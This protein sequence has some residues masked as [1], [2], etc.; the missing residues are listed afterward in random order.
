[1]DQTL[2]GLVPDSTLT[3][4]KTFAA[5]RSAYVRSQIPLTIT[6]TNSSLSFANGLYHTTSPTVSLQGTANVIDTREVQANGTE[7][8]WTAWTGTWTVS[9]IS[10]R[11]GV[12]RVVVQSLNEAGSV[13]ER[14]GV[15]VWYDDGSVQT[16]SGTLTTDT[17]WA[18]ADGPFN[19]TDNLTVGAG[20]TL[21]VEPGTTVYLASGANLT[22]ASGG[23]LLAQGTEV[24]PIRFTR[25]P[26]TT[27]SWGGITINGGAGT[28]ETRIAYAHIDAN[29]STAIH[30][31]GGTLLLDHLT[32]GSPD[33]PYVSLD[34]SSFL[35]QDCVFPTPTAALEPMHGTGGIKA[36]GRGLVLRN[37]FGTTIG[38]SDVFDFTGGNR[39]GQAIL[40]VIGNVFS[41]SSDDE[42]DLDGTDAWIEGNL[43]LHAHKNGSPDTS[44]GISGGSDGS[45]TSEITIV[46]NI[47]YDC[48]QA[49]T[50]KQGNFYVLVNNTMVHQTHQGGLDTDG[51]VICLEDNGAAE[52][53]G[54]YLEGNIL[55]DAEKLVRNLTSATVTFTNNLLPLPW[56][57]LGGNN[58]AADPLFVHVPK[59]DET[60][61]DAWEGA[62]VMRDWLSLLPGS[63]GRGTGP[64]GRDMGAVVPLGA[65]IGGVPAG[66][67]REPGATLTVGF[68]RTGSGISASSWTEGAGYTHYRWRLDGGGWSEETPIAAPIVLSDLASGPHYVEVSGRR[69]CGW[70]QDDPAYGT[71]AG[72]TRSAT[73][74]VDPG[75]I[76]PPPR[77][78]INE[79]LAKN[80]SI[81]HEGTF[82]DLVEFYNDGSVSVDLSGCGFSTDAATPYAFLFPAGTVIP[83]KGLVVAFGDSETNAGGLHLGFALKQSGGALY[84]FDPASRGGQLLDSVRFG[85]QV[86][87]LSIGRLADGSWG[88]TQPTP[89]AANVAQR[90]GDPAQLR[91]NEWLAATGSVFGDD[92]IELYNLD[93]FPVALGGLLVSDHPICPAGLAGVQPQGTPGTVLPPLSFIAGK[94]LVALIA[95]GAV[96]RGGDHLGFRLP[97]E[98]GAISLSTTAPDQAGLPPGVARTGEVLDCVVYGPQ[99]PDVSEGRSPNGAV[100]FGFFDQP[101]PGGGNPG[102]SD[103]AVTTSLFPLVTLTNSWK[104]WQNGDRG[105]TWR[106]ETYDD[107]A[108]PSGRAPLGHDT[109]TMP[110]PYNT[111]LTIGK[112]TYYFRTHFN[113]PTNPAGMTLQLQT[114][115]DDGAAVWLNGQVLYRQSLSAP[116]PTYDTHADSTVDNAALEGPFDID[117]G[118]LR[119]G[120]NV[121][122]VEVHQVNASS[123]DITFALRVDAA[124]T[125]T[126]VSGDDPAVRLN[127][128]LASNASYTNTAGLAPDW[129]ELYNAASTPADLTDHSLTPDSADP[130]RYVFPV[131]SVVPARGFLVIECEGRLPASP[132]NSGFDLAGQGGAIFLFDRTSRG[133]GLLDSI[134]YGVQATD[135][136]IGRVPDGSGRWQ[137]NLPTRGAAD[138]Q[139]ATG[140]AA[141]V[142]INEWMARP[143]SGDDW[144]ELYNPNNQPVELGGLFLSDDLNDRTLSEISPLSYLG[145]RGFAV[146]HADGNPYQGGNHVNFKL[147]AEGES[148]GLFT[149][150]GALIDGVTFGP[151]TDAVSEGRLPDGGA[152]F[153]T[154]PGRATPGASNGTLPVA[155]TD[156]DG[157]PD[158]WEQLYGLNA[159][160]PTDAGADLDGDGLSNLDEYRAGTRPNDPTSSLGLGFVL[161]PDRVT[162]QF[163]AVAG[164]TYSLLYRDALGVG[165]WQKL[166]D[167][168]P[169]PSDGPVSQDDF[170]LA[171]PPAQ[172]YYRLVTPELP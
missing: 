34:D 88:L 21:T 155:D 75:F 12:N 113:C 53:A 45:R 92:F 172:R 125:V 28:P 96:D 20:A 10:L 144:F 121:L 170:L 11:P 161:G 25:L 83:A 64:N 133:G 59:V 117:R 108:W 9:G 149:A 98:E 122:A 13:F 58:S 26:G 30:S 24:A 71:D 132:T 44:S 54:M 127:E 1:M 120:D 95:D 126:N 118:T 38:Y 81:G 3:N 145:P 61:F 140:N 137:A 80:R 55:Y 16:A 165:S 163:N 131:G 102:G 104:Y 69:D 48:D 101:S 67:T 27:T 167:Y 162:L 19:I 76:P 152:S 148:I 84:L 37:F 93:P 107:T 146:F 40:Q 39:P 63:P 77:V 150:Q 142:R 82:P 51:A 42:L 168:G 29:G 115:L 62:Q 135:F 141:F 136:S 111:P 22:V 52:A 105:L 4:L 147:A 49:V 56:S 164:R 68:N 139:A 106:E 70:Y 5:E 6:I 171:A 119:E 130:R 134:H 66:T 78:W 31:N 87:D 97:A 74:T 94:G 15:E 79:V 109:S 91:I 103:T 65:A 153:T 7:A 154:F 124:L 8:V 23:R 17:L 138:I 110:L 50:A 85:M 114:Y 47:F 2:R 36:G 18:A 33:H 128:I 158:A 112:S 169:A 99:R 123:S 14:A 43:F 156:A 73:W 35:V 151:Q 57:G 160:D 72:V 143:A 90:L 100:A 89:G 60:Q 129:I 157:L 159:S 86:P 32:F 116:N 166:A 46:G 41:G